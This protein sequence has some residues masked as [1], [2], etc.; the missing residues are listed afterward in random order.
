MLAL[1][2]RPAAL[3]VFPLHAGAPTRKVY[4]CRMVIGRVGAK[5]AASP[6]GYLLDALEDASILP[7]RFAPF[8]QR[9]SC[10]ACD[11]RFRRRVGYAAQYDLRLVSHECGRR[12]SRVN[13]EEK[14]NSFEPEDIPSTSAERARD[15]TKAKISPYH[16]A[17]T[18]Y[19]GPVT[20]R[21]MLRLY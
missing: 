9:F 6:N 8:S 16:G 13:N 17:E 2:L 10:A 12:S 4:R 7:R 14:G 11:P 18:K 3:V 15:S 1:A 21:V 19:Q 5:P 20:N